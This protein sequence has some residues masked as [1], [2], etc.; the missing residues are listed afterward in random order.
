MESLVNVRIDCEPARIQLPN[1]F[2]PD[3]DG[4]N[5][6]FGILTKAG[7]EYVVEMQIWN[8]WGQLVFSSRDGQARWDGSHKGRPAPA[9]EYA[10]RI[11]VGCVDGAQE[12]YTGSLTLIR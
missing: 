12:V 10:Y 3:G 1:A 2:T 4:I 6:T 7:K 9:D 5:D 8:R 11:V